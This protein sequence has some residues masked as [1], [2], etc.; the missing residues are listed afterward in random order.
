MWKQKKKCHCRYARFLI[1]HF[2]LHDEDGDSPRFHA[3]VGFSPSDV[4][5]LASFATSR[6]NA[7]Q[8]LSDVDSILT[9][10]FKRTRPI[11]EDGEVLSM[12]QSLVRQMPRP[13]EL[14][15]S[16]LAGAAVTAL[17]M[18]WRGTPVWKVLSLL[19]ILSSAW[20]WTHLYKR[21]LSKKHTTLV[22]EKGVP[23]EC[24]PDE[25]SWSH[26]FYHKVFSSRDR[27]DNYHEA[28]LVDPL[29]E[30]SPTMAVAETIVQFIVLPLE[31]LGKH[32][33][34]FFSSLLG[35]L[36][37]LSSTPVLLFVFVATMLI[38]IM[39]FGYRFNFPLFLGSFEPH[40]H[41][42]AASQI[43]D[44]LRSELDCLR[45]QRALE[46]QR[47]ASTSKRIEGTQEPQSTE[48]TPF[49]PEGKQIQSSPS[50]RDQVGE[51]GDVLDRALSMKKESPTMYSGTVVQPPAVKE[52]EDTDPLLGKST[53]RKRLVVRGSLSSPRDTDFEWVEEE[54]E[55][56]D[57]SGAV[58]PDQE[59]TMCEDKDKN[60]SSCLPSS[61]PHQYEVQ[62]EFL[63]KI[64]TVF[65]TNTSRK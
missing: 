32:L 30:V 46:M 50:K 57:E 15:R 48:T 24:F 36:S 51:E 53:P 21:A 18:L 25:M 38:L 33:G 14:L 17:L 60:E 28:L 56:K 8:S 11:S 64:E 59:S 49:G 55:K 65:Q 63:N 19:L 31:H 34:R 3:E 44:D 42:A 29:W 61:Q 39:A 10:M 7:R 52:E 40:R 9:S 1:R 37:W 35:E 26:L 5:I 22:K 2:N 43:I 62:G 20:H 41:S 6:V 45:E 47:E 12:M 16:I 54:E 23:A 4:A 13:E 58:V 27:C